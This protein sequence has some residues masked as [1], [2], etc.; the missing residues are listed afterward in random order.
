MPINTNNI[1]CLQNKV[2]LSM[3]KLLYRII[4]S[5]RATKI[6]CSC[7]FM[8]YSLIQ[9]QWLFRNEEKLRVTEM[10]QDQLKQRISSDKLYFVTLPKLGN[11][12][13]PKRGAIQNQSTLQC[14][15]TYYKFVLPIRVLLL[16]VD[17][18]E[19]WFKVHT[20]TI[21]KFSQGGLEDTIANPK[22]MRAASRIYP[23]KII[24]HQGGQVRALNPGKFP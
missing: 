7:L 11:R 5:R 17:T 19:R 18:Q 23:E 16:H 8:L 6:T 10:Y 3:L 2:T 9:P 14:H 4:K 15:L 13:Q 12:K 20:L 21:G 1:E 24:T 22:E